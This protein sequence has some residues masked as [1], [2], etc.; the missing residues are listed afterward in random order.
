[1]RLFGRLDE[2]HVLLRRALSLYRKIVV[3]NA[4]WISQQSMIDPRTTVERYNVST[5]MDARQYGHR[6]QYCSSRVFRCQP[7][8]G[9]SGTPISGKVDRTIVK[10]LQVMV[11][12]IRIGD[13]VAFLPETDRNS[14]RATR[15]HASGRR[16]QIISKGLTIALENCRNRKQRASRAITRRPKEA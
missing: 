16:D 11:L 10:S 5:V 6:L 12:T 4:I 15:I 3:Q 13:Q 9:M 14:S 8:D 2:Q 7:V 1:M